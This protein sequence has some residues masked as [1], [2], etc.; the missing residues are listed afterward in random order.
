[1]GIF[2]N[3]LGGEGT[4]TTLSREE[5]FVGVLLGAVA[6]DGHISDEEVDD[7]NSF[8]WKAKILK[9][10]HGNAFKKIIDKLFRI[11]KREGVGT[12]LDLSASS[13]PQEFRAGTFAMACD[14]LFSDGTVD[15]DEERYLEEL[16]NKFI[17]D[18]GL[19]KR[20]VEIIALKN[21]V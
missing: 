1:M 20:I 21:K 10:I 16:K 14:L 2:S 11:L 6:V 13:L 12:L 17:L 19:S 8:V 7:F 3:L 18:D 5:A 9:N 15:I 4:P